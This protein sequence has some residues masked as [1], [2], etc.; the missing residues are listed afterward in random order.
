MPDTETIGLPCLGGC[1]TEDSFPVP[2][3]FCRRCFERLPEPHRAMLRTA[4]ETR[5]GGLLYA[6]VLE[7]FTWSWNNPPDGDDD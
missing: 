3:P 1:G 7:A 2:L 6:A 5:D 4:N